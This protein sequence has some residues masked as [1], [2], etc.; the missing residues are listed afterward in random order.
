MDLRGCLGRRR[1]RREERTRHNG[2]ESIVAGRRY[3]RKEGTGTA[4]R[5][6]SSLKRR[7][8]LGH[9][10]ASDR[11]RRGKLMPTG[12]SPRR[13]ARLRRRALWR[14][15]VT[16]SVQ[17]G[18]VHRA[19]RSLHLSPRSIDRRCEIHS[20]GPAFLPAGPR[21][22]TIAGSHGSFRLRCHRGREHRT[23]GRGAGGQGRQAGRAGSR[24][25]ARER[26][27]AL[28]LSALVN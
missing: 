5:C 21:H 25:V 8:Q 6:L 28:W 19:G 13:Q 27:L 18:I 20:G 11:K 9:R 12:A 10:W 15:G 22:R 24:H 16:G 1:S 3:S 2:W 17:G 23:G 14:A 4:G 7:D 26:V